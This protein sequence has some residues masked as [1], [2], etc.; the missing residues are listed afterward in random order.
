ML[1]KQPQKN[2]RAF[3]IL[4]AVTISAI[5]LAIAL[6]V[7][8]IAFREIRFS[9]NARDTNNA[10]FAA[11]TAIECALYYD[12][13]GADATNTLNAFTG[14]ANMNCAG[15]NV[16]IRES[17]FVWAFAIGGMGDTGDAC[18]SV[19]VDKATIGETQIVSRGYNAGVVDPATFQ[20]DPA[21]SNAVERQLDV[22]Y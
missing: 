16:D 4:F 10:L 6:G 9:T 21:N 20:C 3:V 22:N 11:D 8:N 5:L 15:A 12:K 18:A 14:T 7:S 19:T 1:N 17:G 13:G 2:N